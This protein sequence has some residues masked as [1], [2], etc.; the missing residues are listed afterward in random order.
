METIL[1]ALITTIGVI[2]TTIIQGKQAIRKDTIEAKLNDIR[3]SLNNEKLARCKVDLINIMS[4]IENGYV[5]TEQEKIIL[6]EEKDDYNDL[7][8]D[9]YVDDMYD[10]LVKEGKL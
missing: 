7:G 6:K 1:V 5:P 2:S 3:V 10:K 9:S 4:R 8:G